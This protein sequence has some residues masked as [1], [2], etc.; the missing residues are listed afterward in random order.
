LCER[1][2]ADLPRVESIDDRRGLNDII[3][4]FPLGALDRL[5]FEIAYTI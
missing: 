2:L 1:S 5:Q 4:V 3:W